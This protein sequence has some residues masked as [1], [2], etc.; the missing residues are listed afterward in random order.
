MCVL[1]LIGHTI[2][3]WRLGS[4][5]RAVRRVA[6][7]L[8]ENSGRLYRADLLKRY[9][10]LRSKAQAYVYRRDNSLYRFEPISATSD[11][12]LGYEIADRCNRL[13]IRLYG[14]ERGGGN[15]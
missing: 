13:L 14:L 11:T 5:G 3:A 6:K 1:K 2:K 4:D 8:V 7:Y 10:W 15:E 9:N 12:A